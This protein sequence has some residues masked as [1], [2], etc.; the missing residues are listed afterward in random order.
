MLVCMVRFGEVVLGVMNSIRGFLFSK[1]GPKLSRIW[2]PFVGWISATRRPSRREA[3]QMPRR[4]SLS[5]HP[6]HARRP[7]VTLASFAAHVAFLKPLGRK[8]QGCART[9]PATTLP[10]LQP[11]GWHRVSLQS[12]PIVTC[13]TRPL[14]CPRTGRP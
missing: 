7:S 2:V 8:R 13:G 10:T 9:L 14:R 6:V 4:P 1:P 11:G 5:G 3:Q 12:S